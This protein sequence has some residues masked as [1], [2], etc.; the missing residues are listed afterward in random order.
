MPAWLIMIIVGA[1]AGWLAGMIV[2]SESQRLI[3]DI[4]IGIVGGFIGYKLFGG[5]L[6]ITQSGLLNDI[7]TSTAGAVILALVIKLI[8]KASR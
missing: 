7:I 8:R 1:I 4:L 6:N 3:L 5:K 2:D